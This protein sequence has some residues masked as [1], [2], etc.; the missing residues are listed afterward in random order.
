MLKNS[1]FLYSGY[2]TKYEGKICWHP[3]LPDFDKFND[4]ICITNC[5]HDPF[6]YTQGGKECTLEVV[7]PF[8]VIEESNK[9]WMMKTKPMQK[10]SRIIMQGNYEKY[11]KIK[12]STR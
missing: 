12:S 10:C 5:I 6:P 9:R 8:I 2:L 11:W 1:I 3:Q 7:N 4:G